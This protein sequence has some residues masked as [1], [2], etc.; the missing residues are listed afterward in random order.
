VTTPLDF[1]RAL[2]GALNLPLSSN[3]V[4]AVVAWEAA[5][6]GHYAN[7]AHFNPLNTTLREPGSTSIGG[8][9]GV[10]A[11][12][13][14]A[15]GLEATAATL[16]AS[17]YAPIRAALAQS[18]PVVLTLKAIDSTPWGTHFT[19]AQLTYFSSPAVQAYGRTPDP[20]PQGGRLPST[21]A[22]LGGLVG[23]VLAALSAYF[24]TR[25]K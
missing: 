20:G 4:A 22:G 25:K 10:Q 18:S 17:A 9:A 13:S 7:A 15:A 23:L 8:P 5:E 12:I 3:N 2:L 16:K 19:P 1:A 11:Y 24:L 6:G 14:W 21:A